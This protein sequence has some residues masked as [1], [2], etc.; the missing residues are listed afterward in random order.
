MQRDASALILLDWYDPRHGVLTGKVFEYL[1]SPAPIWVVGGSL[2][3]PAA[4][5]VTKAGRGV[6]LGRDPE[7]IRAAIR[8]PGTGRALEPNRAFITG[9][10]RGEQARRFLR[11]LG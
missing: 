4:A 8:D 2:N 3:S 6:A 9:L 5:L 1:R 10:T 7:R 11:L